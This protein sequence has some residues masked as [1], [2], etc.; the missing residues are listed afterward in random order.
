MAE[1][2]PTVPLRHPIEGR[3]TLLSIERA[4][5]VLGYQPSHRWA[6]HV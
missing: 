4:R 6:D 2:F 5:R 1:V 3:Q